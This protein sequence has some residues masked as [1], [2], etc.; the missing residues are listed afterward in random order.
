[1]S[2][3]KRCGFEAPYGKQIC[4]S[5]EVLYGKKQRYKSYNDSEKNGN[6][7]KSMLFGMASNN[8]LIGGILGGN[9]TGGIIGDMLNPGGFIR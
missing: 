4:K 7:T 2:K 9:M 6:F 8:C 1:M 5:C 3:C